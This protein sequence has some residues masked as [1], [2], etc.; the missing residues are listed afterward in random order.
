[1]IGKSFYLFSTNN[2]IRRFIFKLVTRAYF[3]YFIL[4]TIILSSIITA[5]D[6]PL[7]DPNSSYKVIILILI[8]S[9]DYYLV[10]R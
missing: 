8:F 4:F 2:K 3:D 10:Y 7:D 6:N 1:M 5:I 9:S